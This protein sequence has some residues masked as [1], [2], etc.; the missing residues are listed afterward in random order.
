ML[1]VCLA[2]AQ[3]A[4][5][6]HAATRGEGA[7]RSLVTGFSNRLL[8]DA[9]R[10]GAFGDFLVA[11]FAGAVAPEL[12]PGT[13][14]LPRRIVCED[15]APLVPDAYLQNSLVD[16]LMAEGLP[17]AEGVLYS[18]AAPVAS[19]EQRDFLRRQGADAADLESY[20][21]L[22]YLSLLG[23]RAAVVRLVSD[24]ADELADADY[25]ETLPRLS[26]RLS[27]ALLR[28]TRRLAAA[29]LV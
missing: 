11:G 9:F 28:A 18:A 29:P 6:F 20:E 22:K 4:A 2:S 10:Q 26:A 1:T 19:L 14:F 27:D 7:V 21:L 13:L 25:R 15:K 3:E 23:K 24:R 8:K 16:A 12:E 5:Q 17:F